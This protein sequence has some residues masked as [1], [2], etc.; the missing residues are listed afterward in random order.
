VKTARFTRPLAN[1]AGEPQGNRYDILESSD[2]LTSE[3]LLEEKSDQLASA[4]TLLRK[5][6]EARSVK[7][8]HGIDPMYHNQSGNKMEKDS[9]YLGAK[10]RPRKSVHFAEPVAVHQTQ[11]GSGMT[12][13][14]PHVD[15]KISKVVPAL[16]TKTVPCVSGLDSRFEFEAFLGD[17][18]VS[19]LADTGC[20]GNTIN[21]RFVD[22]L[23]KR[24]PLA[25]EITYA[26]SQKEMAQ[27]VVTKT[28]TSGGYVQDIE[29]LVLDTPHD[30]ILG[31]PWFEAHHRTHIQWSKRVFKF[32]V[33]GKEFQLKKKDLPYGPVD[34]QQPRP[35]EQTHED[36][37]TATASVYISTPKPPEASSAPPSPKRSARSATSCST[38]AARRSRAANGPTT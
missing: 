27:G 4:K 6:A 36:A 19:V 26:N 32:T 21:P 2:T 3:S 5:P 29:F 34:S 1:R 28:F 31:T 35:T 23:D 37:S 12:E 9:P 22:S 8:P 24:R 14:P 16:P 11:A 30:I 20:T 18:P 7:L 38:S 25:C 33:D 17:I 15:A 10:P 13:D